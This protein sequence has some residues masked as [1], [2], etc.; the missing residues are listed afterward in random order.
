[1][2]S[3]ESIVVE[4]ARRHTLAIESRNQITQ[5][6]RGLA[7]ILSRH[8]LR[9]SLQRIEQSRADDQ[10]PP[11]TGDLQPVMRAQV[12][13][14]YIRAGVYLNECRTR[15]R[16]LVNV[17][18]VDDSFEL[19]GIDTKTFLPGP[20]RGLVS[21]ACSRL[22]QHAQQRLLRL[23]VGNGGVQDSRKVPVD[24]STH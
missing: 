16:Q 19:S 20:Q 10:G 15:I 5:A 11:F 7:A 17:Q 18:G 1:M 3:R 2:D 22:K 24:V 4:Q 23:R 14:P 9:R 12:I 13:H 6:K 21:I 8:C